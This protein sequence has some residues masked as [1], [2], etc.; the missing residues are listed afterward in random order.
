MTDVNCDTAV[1]LRKIY[2]LGSADFVPKSWECFRQD[3][4]YK[5]CPTEGNLNTDYG[6]FSCWSAGGVADNV[7]LATSGRMNYV[8]VLEHDHVP[9][10]EGTYDFMPPFTMFTNNSCTDYTAVFYESVAKR[11]ANTSPMPFRDNGFVSAEIPQGYHV[12]LYTCEEWGTKPEKCTELKFPVVLSG[13]GTTGDDICV[14][15]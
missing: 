11:N 10:Q 8:Y 3:K 2:G 9:I 15:L 6:T 4:Q 12:V 7:M 13:K 5:F 14:A 1:D